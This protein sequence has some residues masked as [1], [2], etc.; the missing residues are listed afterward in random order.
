MAPPTRIST[1]LVASM[2]ALILVWADHHG[3]K[4]DETEA[5][6]LAGFAIPAWHAAAVAA[7]WVWSELIKP[8]LP[9]PRRPVEPAAS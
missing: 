4:M 7:S 2:S 3:Y 5:A 6:A 1:S 8:Y 9:P